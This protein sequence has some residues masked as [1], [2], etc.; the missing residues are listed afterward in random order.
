[1][2]AKTATFEAYGKEHSE[3]AASYIKEVRRL[4]ELFEAA[5]FHKDLGNT[6]EAKG[7]DNAVAEQWAKVVNI[8]KRL[9]HL[10]DEM[11]KALDEVMD[12]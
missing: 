8:S 1:L 7:L 4:T 11:R 6:S 5:K 9:D 3:L 10:S 12:L 2:D